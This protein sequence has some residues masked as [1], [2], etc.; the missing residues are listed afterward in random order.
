LPT[1]DEIGLDYLICGKMIYME[2]WLYGREENS[3]PLTGVWKKTVSVVNF[4]FCLLSTFVLGRQFS[5]SKSASF[6]SAKC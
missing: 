5:A 6:P 2:I 1:S 4:T 3:E